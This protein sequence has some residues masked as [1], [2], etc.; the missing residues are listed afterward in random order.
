MNERVF[1]MENVVNKDMTIKEIIDI[2][3]ELADIFFSLEYSVLAVQCQAGETLEEA[4]W[5][6][7]LVAM[8]L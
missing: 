8:S 7:A 1:I 5:I 2:D 4:V 3:M 6:M